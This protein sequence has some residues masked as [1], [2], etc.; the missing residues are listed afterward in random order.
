[1]GSQDI[2]QTPLVFIDVETTGLE[3]SRGERICE[4]ALVKTKAGCTL[5]EF[6]SLINPQ[7]E[8]SAGAY[9]THGI[10]ERELI[11]APRF[12][13]ISQKVQ[14]FIEGSILCGYNIGFDLGFLNAEFER[15]NQTPPTNT[16]IDVLAMARKAFPGLSRYNLSS[17]ASYLNIEAHFHR[18]QADVGATVQI[19]YQALDALK[20]GGLTTLEQLANLDRAP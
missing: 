9:L 20:D 13:D 10:P 7:K 15:I 5:D 8:V 6:H 12:G 14:S 4:I 1:M 3:V 18:A 11:E 2:C 19:F 17:V 16:S